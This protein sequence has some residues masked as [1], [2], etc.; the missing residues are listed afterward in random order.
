M[1]LRSQLCDAQRRPRFCTCRCAIARAVR[2]LVR[3]VLLS[4]LACARPKP[5]LLSNPRTG[6][7][8]SYRCCFRVFVGSRAQAG[9][10]LKCSHPSWCSRHAPRS[11]PGRQRAARVQ[12][13]G[14]ARSTADLQELPGGEAHGHLARRQ[15]SGSERDDAR[16]AGCRRQGG[17][18]T[19]LAIGRG[20]GT[21]RSSRAVES[22]AG[23]DGR[24]CAM[25]SRLCVCRA[26]GICTTRKPCM[27]QY[28]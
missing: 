11:S 9:P 17:T 6:E 3:G 25:R 22:R 21:W 15:W 1:G 28:A 12:P 26:H 8:R 18:R 23:A 5:R 16:G 13:G 7:R 19:T 2:Y 4:T 27:S 24:R 20:G 14:C 10:C